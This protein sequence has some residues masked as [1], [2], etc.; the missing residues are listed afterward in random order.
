MIY[1]YGGF[2]AA[3]IEPGRNTRCAQ[4][5][6]LLRSAPPL[7]RGRFVY[8][9]AVSRDSTLQCRT[10]RRPPPW[11]RAEILARAR[12]SKS[13]R[14]EHSFPP[15]DIS[16][17]N[18]LQYARITYAMGA[19]RRLSRPFLGDSPALSNAASLYRDFCV[20]LLFFFDR[21]EFQME[22]SLVQR[23]ASFRLRFGG[24]QRCPRCAEGQPHADAFPCPAALHRRACA[25]ASPASW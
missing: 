16:A 17:A 25:A 23:S 20:V 10:S 11:I 15:T 1:S 5:Y 13:S 24:P 14:L 4:G 2:E 18:M 21:R 22:R 3:L 9:R 7:P 12:P 6:F 19:G 8:R